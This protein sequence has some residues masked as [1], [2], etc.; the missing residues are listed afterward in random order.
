[1]TPLLEQFLSEARD[2]LQGIG[3][4]LLQLE[5]RPDDNS[6]MGELFRLVHT[7]KGNSGLFEFPEMTRVLHAAED[8][9][10]AVRDQ[11]VPYSAPL[12]DQLLEAMDFVTELL[13]EI[14]Q[15]EAI[16]SHRMPQ[17]QHFAEALRKLLHA[18]GEEAP[19]V[20]EP[21]AA[22]TTNAVVD[23]VLQHQQQRCSVMPDDI[24]LALYQRM[25]AGETPL[26]VC[27]QPEEESFYKGEDPFFQV[28]QLPQQEW[29]WVTSREPWPAV[30]ELDAYRC[31]LSF[32]WISGQNELELRE[33][34]R[35][36][37]E[38]LT[39]TPLLAEALLQVSGESELRPELAE[40][41]GQLQPLLVQ[42]Q[43]AEAVAA[44]ER[45]LQLC[46]QDLRISSALRWLA[47]VLTHQPQRHD[48]IEQLLAV[49]AEE[50]G[51]VLET[52]LA[53]TPPTPVPTPTPTALE[54]HAEDSAWSFHVVLEAQREI[55][56]L[57]DR[58]AWLAGRLQSVAQSLAA[59]L[60]SMN[61]QEQLPAL[62]QALQAALAQQSP[63]PLLYC[64]DHVLQGQEPHSL[65]PTAAVISLPALP[66]AAVVPQQALPVTAK[67]GSEDD[68][69]PLARRN[70][71]TPYTT[72]RT[73]KVE[74]SK[75][76][77]LMNLIGE[78]VVAKNA[79]PYLAGRAE[80]V[81]GSREL[82]R[83]IKAQYSVI[84]RIAEEMQD[85]IMQVR[86]MPVS[87]VFQR[88]PRL[89]RDT[90]HRLG[91]EVHLVMEGENTEADKNIIESLADPLIHIVRNSLDH[92]IEMPAE[93]QAAGKPAEGRLSIRASQESDRV[94]IE[95]ADDGRGID[96]QVIRRKAYERGLIDEND[97]ERL[98]D[99]QAIELIFAAGFS[100]AETV[101]DLSG[102][103]VGMDVV[104]TALARVKGGVELSSEAGKGTRLRL[105]LPLSMAV[106]NVMIVESDQQVFGVPM[107]AVVETVRVPR[108]QI[109]WI[110]QRQTTVLRG[111]IVPLVSL[112]ELLALPT[113]QRMN[114][115]GEY[116]A[117]VVRID[118]DHLGILVDDF[119]E[120]VDI[121]LKPLSGVL[122]GLAGY[123]GSALLGDGSVLMVLDPKE[124]V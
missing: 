80:S 86:M 27:Y 56:T 104:R 119:R 84:N 88:F 78:M 109:R 91:K 36:V 85:A 45:A 39:C 93:R 101:T 14:E 42:K 20:P 25:M 115:D 23:S 108:E 40:F 76:D 72:P 75:I 61:L 63:A 59:A 53:V 110:K 65:E 54:Q 3:E 44:I 51:S 73:L 96:P 2:F 97:L 16:S 92:G 89:V 64:V 111:R 87:F 99:Q 81:F 60:Q 37:P 112:N 9:M 11:Q 94:I 74:Q 10:D 58:P 33:H 100:T 41:I 24:R 35:Y 17:A 102:R 83:E 18:A 57:P 26:W 118:K 114:A 43:F 13:D 48:L 30:E 29:Q 49:L 68:N 7:L 71:E 15:A 52:V 38:Q 117:L 106:T 79:L 34:F 124:L 8:L 116:A 31:I 69:K 90:A 113:P 123:A 55:L 50:S 12:A 19:A 21:A 66:S 122:S 121:I 4:K 82:S 103:G 62:E 28:L 47:V 1:M 107:D 67:P 120:T 105:S 32:E 98:T 70:E 95:I 5:D 22:P 6:I 46:A 77:R